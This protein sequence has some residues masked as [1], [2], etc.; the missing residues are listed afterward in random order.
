MMIIEI[1]VQGNPFIAHRTVINKVSVIK[2]IN[3]I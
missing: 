3:L 2:K 1:V